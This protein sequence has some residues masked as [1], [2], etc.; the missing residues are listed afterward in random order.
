MLRRTDVDLFF[1]NNSESHQGHDVDVFTARIVQRRTE[2]ATGAVQV[3]I[4][5][6][7]ADLPITIITPTTTGGVFTVRAGT[8]DTTV[9][10]AVAG[11]TVITD[12]IISFRSPISQIPYP[13][14][15]YYDMGG[16]KI[17]TE[18]I[19]VR[20]SFNGNAWSQQQLAFV[21]G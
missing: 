11:F 20:Y 1:W 4:F 18:Q 15:R 21:D 19:S 6:F 10:S 17:A 3:R 8:K 5:T 13:V 14:I 2:T 9:D 7:I 16:G 12:N